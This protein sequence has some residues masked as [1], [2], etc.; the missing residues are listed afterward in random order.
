[1]IRFRCKDM[2]LKD[3]EFQ[4]QGDSKQE[5]VKIA[6]LHLKNSHRNVRIS[7]EMMKKLRQSVRE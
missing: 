4:V 7:R 3:C 5:I 1:M 2:D 6:S